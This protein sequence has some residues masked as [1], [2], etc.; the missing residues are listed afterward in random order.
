MKE[1]ISGDLSR[2]VEWAEDSHVKLLPFTVEKQK[3]IRFDL[4]PIAENA[5][6]GSVWYEGSK[7]ISATFRRTG[8]AKDILG[9]FYPHWLISYRSRG[10]DYRRVSIREIMEGL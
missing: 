4:V 3:R 8:D 7:T 5:V 2:L 9:M 6:V 10:S 1:G